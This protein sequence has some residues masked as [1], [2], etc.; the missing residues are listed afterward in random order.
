MHRVVLDGAETRA[1]ATYNVS[2][3]HDPATRVYYIE[4]SDIPG[5]HAESASA[6]ELFEIVHDLAA[7]LVPEGRGFYSVPRATRAPSADSHWRG[8]ESL[9]LSRRVNALSK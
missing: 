9:R 6:D 1:M 7:D 5:L 3:K 4:D 8:A 2:V